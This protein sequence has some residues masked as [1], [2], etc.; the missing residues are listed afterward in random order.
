[1]PETD[2]ESRSTSPR[3]HERSCK[4]RHI[5]AVGVAADRDC[6]VFGAIYGLTCAGACWPWMLA[7]MTVGKRHAIAMTVTAIVLF[8][9]RSASANSP[10][11]V[12]RHS[13]SHC[14][15]GCDVKR[16]WVDRRTALRSLANPAPFR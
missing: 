12:C 7:A 1:M 13:C 6:L 2:W 11:W 9:D 8:V 14:D 3:R 16:R 5:G 15:C 10:Q 4:K